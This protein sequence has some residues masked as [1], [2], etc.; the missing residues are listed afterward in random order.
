MAAGYTTQ[1]VYLGPATTG[2]QTFWSSDGTTGG[3]LSP[4]V[5]TA[6][7]ADVISVTLT[8]DTSAYTAGDLLADTQAIT[9]ACRV[10]GGQVELVSL[11]AVDEDDQGVAMDVYVTSSNA[12]A[13]TENSA[14]SI[15][16]ASARSI[17]AIIPIASGDWK[18]L[19]G[20]RVANI[21]NIGAICE[22]SG[23]ADLNV[24]VVNGAGTPTFTANGIKLI[25]GFRQM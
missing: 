10:S 22:G 23:S 1:T 25:F 24:F 14:P 12:T 20:V 2:S 17:Q 15:S 18:D 6:P 11:L 5:V 8:L 13:G 19:G 21:K 7:A 3:N 4:V 9:G 16:D